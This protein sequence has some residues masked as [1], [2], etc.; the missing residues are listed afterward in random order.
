MV[1]VRLGVAI[2]RG[3]LAIYFL[4]PLLFVV[5]LP[6]N[7]SSGGKSVFEHMLINGPK[8]LIPT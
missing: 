5:R 6:W 4:Y 2:Q 1:G 3:V 7:A 8:Y